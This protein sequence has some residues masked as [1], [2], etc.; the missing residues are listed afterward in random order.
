MSGSNLGWLM[1]VD[2]D[3]KLCGIISKT[4]LIRAIQVRTVGSLLENPPTSA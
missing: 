1:V 2:S 4:D 3:G